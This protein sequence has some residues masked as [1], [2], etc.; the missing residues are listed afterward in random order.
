MNPV[1]RKY[2]MIGRAQ[3]I[4]QMNMGLQIQGLRRQ[5]RWMLYRQFRT[6]PCQVL[7]A[8]SSYIKGGIYFEL[9]NFEGAYQQGVDALNRFPD[10]PALLL[11]MGVVQVCCMNQS[12]YF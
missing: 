5:Q 2:S 6:P 10:D 4:L 11:E 7:V 12:N 8:I 1:F 9:G 3:L